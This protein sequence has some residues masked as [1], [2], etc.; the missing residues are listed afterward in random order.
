MDEQNEINRAKKDQPNDQKK[1]VDL[2]EFISKTTVDIL[3]EFE[4]PDQN[5]II[6]ELL[7][8]VTESRIAHIQQNKE[9]TETLTS[10][11]EELPK[12]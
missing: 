7:H 11:L 4:P 6:K 10:L 1:Q 9:K 5:L 3:G 12:L 2:K 8:S